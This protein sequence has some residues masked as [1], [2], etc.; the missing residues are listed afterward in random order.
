MAEKYS[1]RFKTEQEAI[2]EFGDEWYDQLDYS[3]EEEI[4]VLLGKKMPKKYVK[5]YE[6]DMMIEYELD[7]ST[8]TISHE[9]IVKV[10]GED[11]SSDDLSGISINQGGINSTLLEDDEEYPSLSQQN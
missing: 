2:E 5:D 8:Y 6:D 11:D 9:M 1:Y 4:D 3:W 7:E 10:M